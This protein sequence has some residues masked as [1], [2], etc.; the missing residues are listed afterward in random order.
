M[1]TDKPLLDPTGTELVK[2][3]GAD[4]QVVRMLHRYGVTTCYLFGSR[5]GAVPVGTA[6]DLDLAVLF[7]DYEPDRH[8]LHHLIALEQSLGELLAPLKVEVVAL[9]RTRDIA[10][11]FEVISTGL[12][13]YCDDHNFR[14]DFEEIAMRD[15]QDFKPVLDRYYREME[16]DLLGR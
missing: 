15:Y 11:R 1:T 6:S 12:V 2:H 14:T 5:A 16:D 10:L 7:A 13:L 8:D 4:P 9:Q 3:L